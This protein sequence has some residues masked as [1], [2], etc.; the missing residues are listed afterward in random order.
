MKYI[1]IL[2]LSVLF[3]CCEER[4]EPN[5]ENQEPAYVFDALI[6][7][8]P[9]PYSIRI[10]KSYGYDKVSEPVEDAIVVVYCSDSSHYRFYYSNDGYYYSDS[11]EFQATIGMS[12]QM[13]VTT[14]EGTSFVS[15]WDEL[16]PCPE[17]DR[18]SAKDYQ[19]KI[20]TYGSGYHEENDYGIMVMNSSNTNGFT[21]YYRY[22][23]DIVVQTDQYLPGPSPVEV[24]IYRPLDSRKMLCLVD[25]NNYSFKTIIDNQLYQTSYVSLYYKNDS[26]MPSNDY[27]V[28]YSGE[29][30]RVKQYS[31]SKRQYSYWNAINDLQNQTNYLFGQLENEPSGNISSSSND[32]KVLGYFCVSAVKEK[33][34]A[35]SLVIKKRGGSSTKSVKTY[36]TDYFPDID[37]V[38]IYD[39]AK[40]DFFIQFE[41]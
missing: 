9:G 19:A 22:K 40:P 4:Y 21:P 26:L 15:E 14:S 13:K 38:T 18:L 10:T 24:L 39:K 41:N 7:D 31:L 16:L 37:T 5:T 30:V 25:A 20:I 28:R 1:Y 34:M 29:F 8:Q 3:V 36:I 27:Q 23:C 17:I 2:L 32:V 35:C 6:T 12:Y 33:C 11:N